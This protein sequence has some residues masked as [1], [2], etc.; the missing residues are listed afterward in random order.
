MTIESLAELQKKV[1]HYTNRIGLASEIYRIRKLDAE[2]GACTQSQ[3]KKMEKFTKYYFN[4]INDLKNNVELEFAV[5]QQQEELV[6]MIE[7][8]EIHT[9]WNNLIKKMFPV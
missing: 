1:T 7:E 3:Y 2:Y 6:K 9:D 5:T 4:K 8:R